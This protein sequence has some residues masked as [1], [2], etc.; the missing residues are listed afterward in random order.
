MIEPLPITII[1]DPFEGHAGFVRR[2]ATVNGLAPR[3]LLAACGCFT[4]RRWEDEHW[5]ALRALAGHERSHDF[6]YQMFRRHRVT[7]SWHRPT[8]EFLGNPIR[9]TFIAST[10]VRICP[11]CVSQNGRMKEIWNLHHVTACPE[12]HTMLVDRCRCGARLAHDD[13]Q[14]AWSC[15]C[16]QPWG[17]LNSAEASPQLEDISMWISGAF[18]VEGRGH[19]PEALSEASP[20]DL[21]CVIDTVMTAASTPPEQDRRL[22]SKSSVHDPKTGGF[23]TKVAI[24]EIADHLKDAH[25]YLVQ[26]PDSYFRLLD[27]IAGRNEAAWDEAGRS[28]QGLNARQLF[29]TQ[30]GQAIRVPSLNLEGRPNP[31]LFDAADQYC[32]NR[33][34]FRLRR[35]RPAHENEAVWR[36]GQRA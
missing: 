10:T 4:L 36:C 15:R 1:P 9:H 28:R 34:G 8:I 18:G 32:R 20:L 2:L 21:L 29:A 11:T 5:H 30:V 26:W 16:G 23:S 33:H 24:A 22:G 14:T 27:R 7:K 25:Q 12:H 19:R 3:H 35:I 6:A 17:E 13:T 31:L